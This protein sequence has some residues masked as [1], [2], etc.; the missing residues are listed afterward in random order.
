MSE[1]GSRLACAWHRVR[2]GWRCVVGIHRLRGHIDCGDG[3][4]VASYNPH[5]ARPAQGAWRKCEWCGATW[6][7]AYD[8]I[9]PYWQRS[10]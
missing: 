8:G 9:A 6:V 10:S 4:N 1:K 5:A 7:A 2:G 3:V